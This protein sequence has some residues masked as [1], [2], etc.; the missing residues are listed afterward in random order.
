MAVRAYN[1]GRGVE[2]PD[3]GRVLE[4]SSPRMFGAHRHSSTK[5]PSL[6]RVTLFRF[7]GG[8]GRLAEQSYSNIV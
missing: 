7:A 3:V 4:S 1:G 8:D 5:K 2:V 6:P